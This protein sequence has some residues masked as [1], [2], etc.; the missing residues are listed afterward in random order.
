[1]AIDVL[2][3]C[4]F[5]CA[6]SDSI[7]IQKEEISNWVRDHLAVPV[8]GWDSEYHFFDGSAK[9]V[10]Y[11]LLLDA[12]NFCFFPEPRWELVFDG[13]RL[14]GYFALAA[15]L[16]RAFQESHPLT[17]F[18]RLAKIDVEAVRR[19]LQD[20]TP[21][22]QVPLLEERAAILRE[23]GECISSLYDGNPV[24]LVKEAHESASAL[25]ERIVETF[26]SFRD[27]ADYAGERI[28]FYKRAQIFIADLF[29]CFH[30]T[31][32]GAFRDIQLLT[33]FADYKL[34]QFLRATGIL[35]YAPELADHV[36]QQR[37][38][39]AGSPFEV[40][41]RA[42]TVVTVDLLRREF[43][44]EGRVLLPIEVDWSLWHA[45]QECQNMRPHHRTLTT[46]Y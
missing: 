45:A 42:A 6:Q 30:G 24:R 16:K 2:E 27:E 17:D 13:G 3:S 39:E 21:I 40:E 1:M 5:V 46:F 37:W 7:S 35:S 20:P 26:P 25:L 22:G 23:L 28:A 15:A 36:D 4:R 32:Y 11:C 9:T 19:V 41:I 18:D 44:R 38:I 10:A 12:L 43:E 8:P 33:A 29:G 31:S 14:Q 34:P